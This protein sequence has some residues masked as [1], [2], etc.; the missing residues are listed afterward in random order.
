L[1]GKHLKLLKTPFPGTVSYSVQ[2]PL[3]KIEELL[4]SAAGNSAHLLTN[5]RFADGHINLL[6]E[7]VSA[8]QGAPGKVIQAT[9]AN[10]V[11]ESIEEDESERESW[12]LD[13]I[14][15]DCVNQGQ[16]WRFVLNCWSVE[17]SWSSEWPSLRTM[18]A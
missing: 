7:P 9:F 5:F 18:N 13:I 6:L 12:P 15:F 4:F 17:W 2:M 8:D 16:R 14:G 3:S 1:A 11:I 10:A